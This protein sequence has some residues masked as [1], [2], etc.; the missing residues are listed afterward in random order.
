MRRERLQAPGMSMA[1][2]RAPQP[3]ADRTSGKS[4]N[5]LP[6]SKERA[7]PQGSALFFLLFEQPGR[8][9]DHGGGSDYLRGPSAGRCGRA[10]LVGQ[11]GDTPEKHIAA[12]KEAAGT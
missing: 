8:T 2:R 9:R 3:A 12:A 7:E 5:D 10:P 6:C 11:G 1:A 4:A